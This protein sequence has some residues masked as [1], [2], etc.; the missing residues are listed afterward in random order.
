MTCPLVQRRPGEDAG[1]AARGRAAAAGGSIQA[2]SARPPRVRHDLALFR[3]GRDGTEAWSTMAGQ[4]VR[5]CVLTNSLAATDVTPVYAGYPNM[6][7]APAGRG[8]AVRA[9]ARGPRAILRRAEEAG[10]QPPRRACMP[11]PTRSTAAAIFVGSFNLDPR[12]SE[13]E[14]GDGLDH[15]QLH[16]RRKAFV[17]SRACLSGPGLQGDAGPGR[18]SSL[19]RRH[20]RRHRGRAERAGSSA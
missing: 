7:G 19:G 13:A 2:A 15:R 10:K 9:Q 12:S 14:H 1:S 17:R 5:V 20:N 8:A 4:G 18:R 6:T 16:A 11:R 3:A